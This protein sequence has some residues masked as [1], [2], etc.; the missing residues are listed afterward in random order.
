MLQFM[1][2]KSNFSFLHVVRML[3][4]SQSSGIS[5]GVDTIHRLLRVLPSIT[6]IDG[7]KQSLLQ[8]LPTPT[9]DPAE[10]CPVCSNGLG[11]CNSCSSSP[12][13]QSCQIEIDRCSFSFE[14]LPFG[15]NTCKI[16]SCTI[17]KAAANGQWMLENAELCRILYCVSHPICPFC[18]IFMHQLV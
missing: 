2:L 13:C 3:H 1:S 4:H 18:G 11:N 15:V 10:L 7:L 12:E 16:Y 14:L 8:Q 9:S 17:C 5:K 6:S